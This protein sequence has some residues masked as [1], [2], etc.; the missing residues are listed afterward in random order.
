[1]FTLEPH[2]A[3]A[4]TVAYHPREVGEAEHSIRLKVQQNPFEN[5][6]VRLSGEAYMEDVVY[7][8]LPGD[9]E[10]ELR[11]SDGPLG[12]PR[13]VA[14]TLRNLSDKHYHFEWPAE[15]EGISISPQFG[16]LHAG[17][18]KD[19]VVTFHTDDAVAHDAA[20]FPVDVTP[21]TY[22]GDPV[23][24]D[25]RQMVMVMPGDAPPPPPVSRAIGGGVKG[26]KDKGGKAGKEKGGKGDKEKATKKGG[27]G[28][29]VPTHVACSKQYTLPYIANSH[30]H[31]HTHTHARARALSLSFS[32]SLSYT[33]T[34]THK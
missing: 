15:L 31:T 33:H 27:K 25:D 9:A 32:L 24:W 18:S 6:Q 5:Y 4:F 11:F 19:M 10:D 20:E 8:G 34:H 21:I 28:V 13:S 2:K 14:F 16:H 23:D 22:P 1:V 30:T 12:V 26:G 7:E 17:A 29:K 3:E